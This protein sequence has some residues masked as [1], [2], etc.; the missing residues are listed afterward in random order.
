MSCRIL[1][2]YCLADKFGVASSEGTRPYKYNGQYYIFFVNP[3]VAEYVMRSTTVL[4][5]YTARVVTSNAPGPIAGVGAPVQGAIV[6]ANSG[7]WY[8]MCFSWAFP[9]GRVPILAPMTWSSDGWPSVN[10]SSPLSLSFH[11]IYF[12][13][14]LVNGG[15]AA[16][17][18]NTEPVRTVPAI[19]GTDN[20][21]GTTLNPRWEWNHDPDTAYYTVNNGLTLRTA[22]VTNDIY[23]ARNT[24]TQRLPGTTATATIRL[25]I[26]SMANGDRAGLAMFKD[27]SAA[28]RL[29]KDNGSVVLQLVTGMDLDQTLST[30]SNGVVQ[31]TAAFTGTTVYLRVTAN[32]APTS[33]KLASFSYSTNGSSFTKLGP[34]YNLDP[35]WWL[36]L[37]YRFAI[38]NFATTALGGSITVNSYTVTTP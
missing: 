32:S 19:T 9:I 6:K 2:S 21:S 11:Y 29:A 5:Q 1:H 10:V 8:Y 18:P 12:V 3:G 31:A 36:F 27:K 13:N 4:G 35:D 33:D 30:V 20:F 37:G 7:Q 28:I 16:S 34:S 22:T 15:I 17:Y 26:G 25:S 23:T 38:F 14:Q 24:L